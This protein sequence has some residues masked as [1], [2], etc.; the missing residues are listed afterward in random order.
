[1][2]KKLDCVYNTNSRGPDWIKVKPESVSCS[3]YCRSYALTGSR[4]DMPIRWARTL[5]SSFW[6]DGGV[7][8]VGQ[9][10]SRVC[11]ADSGSSRRTTG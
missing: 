10:R 9:E 5:I 1:M 8:A 2:V 6:A 3:S 11:S 4:T 7:K